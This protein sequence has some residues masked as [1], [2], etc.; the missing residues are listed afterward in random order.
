MLAA[1]IGSLVFIGMG[2]VTGL[3]SSAYAVAPLSLPR[4]HSPTLAA[5]GWTILLAAVVAVAVFVIVRIGRAVSAATAV[6]PFV[7]VPLVA[8]T[9]GGLAIAFAHV[10]GKPDDLVLFSGQ[11][12]MAAVVHQCELLAMGVCC[13]LSFQGLR[14]RHFLGSARGGPTFPAMFLGIVAGLLCGHLP[15]F[16]ETPPSP[17]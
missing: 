12:A 11:E 4:Y 15:G 3:S 5:F 8:L 13:S 17:R 14:L 10:T 16:S 1:G 7:V 6:R 2:S 9:V